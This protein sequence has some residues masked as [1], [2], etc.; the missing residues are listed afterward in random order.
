MKE[1][2][3]SSKIEKAFNLKEINYKI[4]GIVKKHI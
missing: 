3:K 4:R 2:L 1:S